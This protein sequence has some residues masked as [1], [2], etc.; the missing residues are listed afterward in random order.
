META[1]KLIILG[2]AAKY[3]ASC[4]SSGSERKGKKGELG[5]GNKAGICHSWGGDGR[6]ISLLKILFTNY[7]IYDCAY[8]IN[9]KSN[10]VRRVAFTVDE[11]VSLT[12]NFYKRNYIE[13][14]FLSSGIIKNP[15]YTMERLI[16]VAKKL[17]NEE[18]FHG[19]IHLKTIPG[20]S[21]LLIK[22]AGLYADRMSVNIELPSERS[23][24]LLTNKDRSSILSPMKQITTTIY[25][26]SEERKTSKKLP[27]FAPAGQTT[28]LIV[29][30]TP[31][32][33]LK[34]IK[35]TEAI[36]K[37]FGLKRVYYSAFVPGSSDKRLPIVSTPPLAREHR[38][39]QADWLLR[40][41]NFKADELISPE[42]PY[43][44]DEID[45]KAA[46]AMRNL[47]LFPVEINR[48]SLE[49][50]LRVPGIGKTSALKII[51]ARRNGQLNFEHLKRINVVL[52][53]A[54]FFIT[55]KGK[56]MEG[57]LLK[58]KIIYEAM[59]KTTTNAGSRDHVYEQLSLF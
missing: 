7:C 41:Y 36:Y 20:A 9:R 54:R 4:S 11:V 18:N 28:Q 32:S 2:D 23:L 39:Y 27:V 14:L 56:M 45:P 53:R 43:L 48:A 44:S 10:D 47:H 12:M 42:H 21:E 33:D 34:I 31:E 57:T 30:A 3:D 25:E 38:L 59:K 16:L 17:R 8:C 26:N 37:K 40:F 13:G 29:G 51:S 1:Q 15:D 50:L 52:K 46:W 5:S 58:E 22:E 19:Y 24:L 6:C 49:T 35:L 55:C